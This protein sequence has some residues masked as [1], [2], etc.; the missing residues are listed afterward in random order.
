MVLTLSDSTAGDSSLDSTTGPSD[1]AVF[2]SRRTRLV[3]Q[4]VTSP[5]TF[6][7]TVRLLL[8]M[9]TTTPVSVK[10]AWILRFL[11]VGR[12]PFDQVRIGVGGGVHWPSSACSHGFLQSSARFL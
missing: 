10:F 6:T 8:H 9:L 1:C 12:R 2:V 4:R 11:V 3:A 7:T 5:L